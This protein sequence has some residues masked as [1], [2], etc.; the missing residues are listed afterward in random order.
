MRAPGQDRGHAMT[1][2]VRVSERPRDSGL[3]SPRR[4][5][6]HAGMHPV[7]AGR[8]V[9]A[10]AGAAFLIAGLLAGCSSALGP[11]RRALG[12]PR[13]SHPIPAG[14]HKIKHVIIVMQENRSFDSY[15][16]TYPG[17]DGIPWNK[18]GK[19]TVCLPNPG[20]GC[21]RPYHDTADVNAGGPHNTADAVADVD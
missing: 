14:I 11:A 6:E 13:G 19:P 8:R 21:T 9:T 2:L 10:L 4:K 3:P 18:N 1:A 16:G 15:F 7:R 5:R 20:H 17:A 12:K